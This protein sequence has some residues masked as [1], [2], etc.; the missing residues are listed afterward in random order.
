MGKWIAGIDR[1]RQRHW[2]NALIKQMKVRLTD[3]WD[4]G[5]LAAFDYLTIS[6]VVPV[7]RSI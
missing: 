1:T 2:Y 7:S 6:G 4:K 5:I 3:V